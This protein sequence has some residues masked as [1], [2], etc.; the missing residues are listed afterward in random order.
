[1][2]DRFVIQHRADL[3]DS[4]DPLSATMEGMQQHPAFDDAVRHYLDHILAWRRQMGVFNRVATTSGLHAIG[5]LIFLHYANTSGRPENGATYSRLLELCEARGNCGSRALRTI[6][7]LAHVMGYVHSSRSITDRRI[8][9]FTPSEKLLAESRQQFTIPFAC[10]DKL[11]PGAGY[12][13]AVKS[14]PAF[15]PNLFTT[16]GKAVLELGI[17]I[18]EFFPDMHEIMQFQGGCPANLSIAHAVMHGRE[19][20]SASA[21]AKEFH[22]S[23]AQVR[24]V[25]KTAA[26][27]G[28]ITLSERGQVIDAGPLVAQ[29]KGMIA[30]ELSLY[31]K[32]SLGLEDYFLGFGASAAR[33]ANPT[34]DHR[35]QAMPG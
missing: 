11:V 3:E 25:L 31:A 23:P 19:I 21:I 29:Q 17:E 12:T 22:V 14:D 27:R 5:Y 20:A 8:Q 15:L 34:A 13:Q 4:A 28:L 26:N 30:R 9:I 35:L 6:L 10:L 2:T 1:L 32:Y 33:L 24:T 18:T 7:V 16:T